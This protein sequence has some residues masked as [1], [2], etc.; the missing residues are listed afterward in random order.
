MAIGKYGMS[1]LSV[2]APTS[3]KLYANSK[4]IAIHNR[5]SS[6][7]E[8]RHSGYLIASMLASTIESAHLFLAK[9]A[10]KL[11]MQHD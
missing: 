5:D 4:T 6:M 7:S 8:T 3:T 11:L 2:I 10:V 1:L 9:R